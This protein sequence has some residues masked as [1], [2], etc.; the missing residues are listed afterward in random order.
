LLASTLLAAALLALTLCLLALRLA[1]LLGLRALL[2]L[3]A[4]VGL[5]ELDQTRL[6][7]NGAAERQRK[8]GSD[9]Q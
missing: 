1:L 3:G 4:L 7:K 5:R 2:P 9:K 8:G 6:R